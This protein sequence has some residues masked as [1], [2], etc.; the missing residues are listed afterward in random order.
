[1]KDTLDVGIT[2]T[3]T[4][5][6]KSGNTNTSSKI[7]LSITFPNFLECDVIAEIE[8]LSISKLSNNLIRLN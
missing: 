4:V 1:V 7:E 8:C 2:P 5:R 3:V 6:A